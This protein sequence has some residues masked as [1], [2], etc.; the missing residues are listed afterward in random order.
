[1]GWY[2]DSAYAV[3]VLIGCLGWV[4]DWKTKKAE[5]SLDDEL[6]LG[7]LLKTRSCF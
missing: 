1:M 6:V 5:R 7:K 2:D 4:D 3:C